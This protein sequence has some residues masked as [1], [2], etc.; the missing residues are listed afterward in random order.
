MTNEQSQDLLAG[1][2]AWELE[3]GDSPK[4]KSLRKK[5]APTITEKTISDAG[6]KRIAKCGATGKSQDP[7]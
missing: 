4:K 2:R 7:T 3:N 1:R 5:K 6:G